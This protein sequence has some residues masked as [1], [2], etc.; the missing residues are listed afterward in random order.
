MTIAYDIEDDR[1]LTL[2]KAGDTNA[3]TRFVEKHFLGLVDAAQQK[4]CDLEVAEELAQD[5]MVALYRNS[6][7]DY[8]PVAFCISVLKNK[9]I[10][11]YR[12]RKLLVVQ[13]ANIEPATGFKGGAGHHVEF[14]ELEQ[15]VAH[16]ISQLPEQVRKVFLLRREGNLSNREVAD[17]L[18]ISVKMVE[19]HMT[20]AMKLLKANLD[21]V[22]W[23][24]IVVTAGA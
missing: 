2:W 16:Y 23:L 4:G 12:R 24:G 15:Q 22:A 17:Q 3:F 11:E 9:V 5:T 20:K 7:V 6:D 10:D 13:P 8:N 19:A 18:G 14:K 1:L 21:Y